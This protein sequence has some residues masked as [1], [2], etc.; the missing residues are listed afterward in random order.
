[1]LRIQVREKFLK[2]KAQR[3]PNVIDYDYDYIASES[4]DYDYD[5]LTSYNRMQSITIDYDYP[6]PARGVGEYFATLQFRHLHYKLAKTERISAEI[7]V[8]FKF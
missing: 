4:N 8:L 3:H 7:L 6:F 2:I 5:Y 1:M